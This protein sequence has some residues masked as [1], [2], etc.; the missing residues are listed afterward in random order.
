MN[1]VHIVTAVLLFYIPLAYAGGS[2]YDNHRGHHGDRHGNPRPI[3][4]EAEA[5]ARSQSN[6]SSSANS[7]SNSS[8]Y[9][10]AYQ[11]QS[12]SQWQGQTTIVDVTANGGEGG[13]G[14]DGGEAFSYSGGATVVIE[15]GAVNAEISG[16][17]E[18]VAGIP[19][20]GAPSAVEV[21]L[22]E[23]SATTAEKG[24]AMTLLYE[25]LCKPV[26]SLKFPIKSREETMGNKVWMMF[27]PHQDYLSRETALEKKGAVVDEV[28]AEHAFPQVPTRCLGIL[29][30]ESASKKVNVPLSEIRAASMEY[31]HTRLVGFTRVHIVD[32]RQAIAAGRGVTSSGGGFSLLPGASSLFG[33]TTA[34]LGAGGAYNKGSTYNLARL[35][36]T[37]IVLGEDSSG[38]II[39][40]PRKIA[41][42]MPLPSSKD[43]PAPPMT[44]KPA[45]KP[46]PAKVVEKK[47]P[48]KSVGPRWP[49]ISVIPPNP[50]K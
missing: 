50:K 32:M 14:G 41:E 30:A 25:E 28:V 34:V 11:N 45:D 44:E 40:P 1:I 13:R 20:T 6:A 42:V 21:Q 43:P 16:N 8:S 35:G 10:N 29:T 39:E 7:N 12:Q 31:I 26:S 24:I 4:N 5:D 23:L 18:R 46:L 17:K 27:T 33:E 36:T 19:I 48:I 38:T 9:S 22:Y 37:F 2:G 3:H 15:K 49:G 47:R